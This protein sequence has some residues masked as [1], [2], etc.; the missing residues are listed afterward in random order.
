MLRYTDDWV[1]V[2]TRFF[3]CEGKYEYVGRYVFICV[4]FVLAIMYK[5]Y[6]IGYVLYKALGIFPC[7]RVLAN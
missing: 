6:I 7:Y 4:I 2:F 5:L 1:F 3:F